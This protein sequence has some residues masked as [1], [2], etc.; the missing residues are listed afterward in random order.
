MFFRKKAKAAAPPPE[1]AP[2]PAPLTPAYGPLGEPDLRGLGRL[3]WRK[4]TLILGVT[5][6]AAGAAF[7][8]V[9]AITPRFRSE[10]RLLL[11]AR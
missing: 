4:K 7:V 10:S 1:P 8:I 2:A 6:C 9:N 5:L 11:E 3:L